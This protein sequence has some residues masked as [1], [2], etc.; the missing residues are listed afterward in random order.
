MRTVITNAEDTDVV[1]LA[2]HVALEIADVL[3]KNMSVTI[4][5]E[6]HFRQ[7]S[8]NSL[9]YN[10]IFPQRPYILLLFFL[11]LKKKKAEFNCKGLYS[12]KIAK[13]IISLYVNTGADAVSDILG[14]VKISF[15]HKMEKSL[16]EA[17][18]L[19]NG[20]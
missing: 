10:S 20:E 11:G 17:I 16:Q 1:V 12:A 18:S 9:F 4:L 19:V 7:P 8:I 3:D 14:Q 6:I 2:T 5:L 13:I 15:W